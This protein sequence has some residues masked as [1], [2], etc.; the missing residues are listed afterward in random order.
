[1]PGSYSPCDLKCQL[2]EERGLTSIHCTTCR[3][4]LLNKGWT[5][6]EMTRVLGF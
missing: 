3:S 5:L 6:L 4:E 1:M 2:S